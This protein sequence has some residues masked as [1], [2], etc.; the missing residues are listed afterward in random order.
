MKGGTGEKTNEKVV[1]FIFPDS[2][3]V[4]ICGM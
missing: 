1:C 4:D 3:C 2:A